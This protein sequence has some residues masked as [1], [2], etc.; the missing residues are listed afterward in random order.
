[1]MCYLW[2]PLWIRTIISL[3]HKKIL[4]MLIWYQPIL[5]A[6]VLYNK[7]IRVVSSDSN[8]YSLLQIFVLTVANVIGSLFFVSQII[9]NLYFY[10][11]SPDNLY[12]FDTHI[13]KDCDS[14]ILHGSV[15]EHLNVYSVRKNLKSVVYVQTRMFCVLLFQ[16]LS[17]FTQFY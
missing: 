12:F 4:R 2:Y 10:F 7:Q 3:D 15:G 1:M 9:G 8:L 13:L 16:L 5:Q 11:I 17:S 14:H 6:I